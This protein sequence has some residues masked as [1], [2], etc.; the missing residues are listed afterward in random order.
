MYYQSDV[1]RLHK[2]SNEF[3]ATTL[4]WI[5]WLMVYSLTATNGGTGI[6]FLYCTYQWES[7]CGGSGRAS[8]RRCSWRRPR[9][10]RTASR[11]RG[12]RAWGR[13]G[14]TRIGPR[15]TDWSPPWR[16]WRPGPCL[17]PTVIDKF[18][19]LWLVRGSLVEYFY[20]IIHGISIFSLALALSMQFKIL[21]KV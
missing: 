3:N 4:L 15:G 2:C 14:P 19:S 11:C 13:T 16:W 6:I 9:G 18:E 17:M 7:P 20:V 1:S 21:M 8:C 12:W 10:C 5:Q